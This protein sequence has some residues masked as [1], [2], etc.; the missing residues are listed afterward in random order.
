MTTATK[1]QVL[2]SEGGDRFVIIGTTDPDTALAALRHEM[3][4][5]DYAADDYDFQEAAVQPS[6]AYVWHTYPDT[7]GIDPD[8]QFLARSG[9]APDHAGAV[10]SA[11]FTAVLVTW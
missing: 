4:D 1:P 5:R 3:A 11:T 6:T 2:D 9:E 10:V 7:E 8:M